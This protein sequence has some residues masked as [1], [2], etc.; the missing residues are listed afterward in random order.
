ML[1][2]LVIKER[3]QS[4]YQRYDFIILPVMK[5]IIA[6]V[7][8]SIIN[9]QLGYNSKL[10]NIVIVL[11]LSLLSTFTPP[12]VLVLLAAAVTIG[13]VYVVLNILTIGIVVLFFILY[14]LFIRF[15]PKQGYVLLAVPILY[16]LKIP[17]VAPLLL[18]LVSTPIAII[19]VSCGVVVYYIFPIITEAAIPGVSGNMEDT[20]KSFMVLADTFISNQQMLI[21]IVVFSLILIITYVIRKMTFDY[22]FEIAIIAGAISNILIFLIVDL[23]IGGAEQILAMILGT[24]GSAVI[25]FVIQFFRQCLDYTAVERVQ[26]EDDDYYYYVKAVPKISVTS[27]EKNIKRI[28]PQRF[29]RNEEDID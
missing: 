24:I 4:I 16:I 25:V 13:H 3:I 2:L 29:R 6:F 15:T 21:T 19:S 22:A 8:F 9:N 12:A 27:P 20:L 7:V 17:Y 23:T 10:N 28:N 11:A 18:G 5:F 26:F 1:N 14:F